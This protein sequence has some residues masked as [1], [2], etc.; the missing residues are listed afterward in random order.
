M[1]PQPLLQPIVLQGQ[2]LPNRV[3]MAPLTRARA[4]N[5]WLEPGELQ[6]TYYAQRAGSRGASLLISEGTW[7]SPQA[8]GW[9]DVP[10]LYTDRQVAGW[11]LVTD[12][13]HAKGGTILAQLWH[14]GSSSHPSFFEGH[15]PLAPSAVNPLVSTPTASGR[16]ATVTP[17]AM[18]REDIKAAVRSFRDATQRALDAGFDGVQIQAGYLY[19]FNQFLNPRTNQRTDEYG[20]SVE[21]RSRFLFEVLEELSKVID[22]RKV[23]VKTGPS[24]GEQGVF[25]SHDDTVPTS[26]Y[27]IRRLNGYSLHHLLM[28]GAMSDLTG[29]PAAFLQGDEMFKH[30]RA[31]YKGLII[32]NVG[33][34]QERGNRLIGAGLVDMVAFGR[35]FIANPDLAHRFSMG[36][37]VLPT[38]PSIH[39]GGGARGYTD[40]PEVV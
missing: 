34:D 22:L 19:L 36:A 33:I 26:D 40:F 15:L 16:Q 17:Q 21:N 31:I 25:V 30:Y 37:E 5:A 11:R 18:S 12:A 39:Y 23:G 27:V 28:M 2:L 35:S 3:V 7:V 38:D 13:V 32:A 20:G 1:T 29:T 10:G 6:A 14:T 8:I 9:A 4:E 24:T